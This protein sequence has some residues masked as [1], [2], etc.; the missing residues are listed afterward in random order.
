MNKNILVAELDIDLDTGFI[1]GIQKMENPDC[2]GAAV[3]FITDL[4]SG[5]CSVDRCGKQDN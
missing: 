4:C 3:H 5:I 2:R 1:S